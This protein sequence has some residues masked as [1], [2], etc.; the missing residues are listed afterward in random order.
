[1]A[2]DGFK[3]HLAKYGYYPDKFA[4]NIWYHTTKKTKFCLCVDDF[5]VQY[6]S[7]DDI[8]HLINALQ[9]KYI[10]TTDFSGNNF[11]G[12]DIKWNYVNGWVDISMIK[13]LS[14]TLKRLLH[15]APS[16]A[17]HA[18]HLWTT[19]KYGQ[20]RQYVTPPDTSAILDSKGIKTVQKVVGSFLI[21]HDLVC[22]FRCHIF[23][24]R[25]SKKPYCRVLLL[26]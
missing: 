3:K 21:R 18:P 22:G 7:Q 16:R 1:M 14:K 10:V 15:K 5:G 20:K 2:Y 17:Q 12:L 8:N 26:Q 4:Q 13:Y 6:F 25:E 11:C 24:G 19:P 23:G 9:D